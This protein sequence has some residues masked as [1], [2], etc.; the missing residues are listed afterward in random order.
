MDK[1]VFPNEPQEKLPCQPILINVREASKA[2][3]ISP[4][5]LWELTSKA[6]IPC[7]R[8]GRRVLYDPRD[9]TRWIDRQ[10]MAIKKHEDK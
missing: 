6:E 2:L 8:I 3:G 4:R 1:F 5:K 9:L 10:K 7:V